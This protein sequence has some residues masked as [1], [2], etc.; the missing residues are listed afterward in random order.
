MIKNL[1]QTHHIKC[2]FRETEFNDT[3]T[4]QYLS[5]SGITVT[6]LDPLGARLPKGPGVYE[7]IMLAIGDTLQSCLSSSP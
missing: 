3:M 7:K 2:V 4:K 6:E 5:D 1:I